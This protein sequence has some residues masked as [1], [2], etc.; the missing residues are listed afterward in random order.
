MSSD[1]YTREVQMPEIE[2]LDMF[3]NEIKVGTKVIFGEPESTIE[4]INQTAEV[5]EISEPDM[6]FHEDEHGCD[7]A[8]GYEV[9][10]T[11]KF[12]DGDIENCT[13][14]LTEFDPDHEIY[15]DGGDLRVITG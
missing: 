1:I 10:I 9:I 2:I 11:I 7:I 15:E 12:A 5:T 8:D 4:V 13:A 14:R 3:G 6:T